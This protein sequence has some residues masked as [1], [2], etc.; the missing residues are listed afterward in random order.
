MLKVT[1]KDLC[2]LTILPNAGHWIQQECP[3]AVNTPLINF[4][5]E[6]KS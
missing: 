1:V 3:A 2:G 6:L 5:G 4:L